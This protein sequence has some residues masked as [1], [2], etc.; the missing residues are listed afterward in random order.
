MTHPEARRKHVLDE[1]S[2]TSLQTR[3]KGKGKFKGK[4]KKNDS[5]KMKIEKI[6][7]KHHLKYG[8]DEEHC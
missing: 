6:T 5:I 8:H 4:C 2:E 7:V 1:K 3:E